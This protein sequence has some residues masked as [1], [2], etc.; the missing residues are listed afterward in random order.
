MEV[1]ILNRSWVRQCSF[2]S[3][4]I[5]FIKQEFVFCQEA[6]NHNQTMFNVIYSLCVFLYV[7]M[8]VRLRRRMKVEAISYLN[9]KE[10]RFDVP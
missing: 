1:I 4:V 9:S 2:N 3:W 6:E 7:C 10:Y 8:Y 5:L